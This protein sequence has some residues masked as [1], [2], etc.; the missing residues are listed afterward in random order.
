VTTLVD[1]D[2]LTAADL[3]DLAALKA[4][5]ERRAGDE[6]CARIHELLERPALGA[7]RK[8]REAT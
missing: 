2:Q 4:E 6:R 3:A 5:R 1:V 7:C 8:W